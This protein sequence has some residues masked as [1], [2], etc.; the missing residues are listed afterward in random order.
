MTRIP[1]QSEVNHKDCD[2]YSN[3]IDTSP[4]IWHLQN[5]TNVDNNQR[6]Q[7]HDNMTDTNNTKHNREIVVAH[8]TESQKNPENRTFFCIMA[9]NLIA[10]T[11]TNPTPATHCGLGQQVNNAVSSQTIL[12]LRTLNCDWTT[13]NTR[14]C[15]TTKSERG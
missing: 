15:T 10:N 13:H 11:I 6:I 2:K 8:K 3:N 7:R 14:T 12:I 1:K 9:I 4:Y 5:S